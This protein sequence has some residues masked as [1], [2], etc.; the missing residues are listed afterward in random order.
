M[1]TRKILLFLLF[2][3][4]ISWISAG[5]VYLAGIPYGSTISLVVT[6]TFFMM[7]PAL[8][9]VIVQ[10][11][12]YKLP[13]KE[14]GLDFK[15]TKWRNMLWIALVQLLI[16]VFS[17]GFIILLGNALHIEA[18]G[19]YSFDPEMMNGRFRELSAAQGLAAVPNL[20]IPPVV[21][22]IIS[23]GS[24]IL[25]GGFIN[26]IFTFGEEL[27]WRGFLYNETRKLGFWKSNLLIGTIW[28]LWHAPL[29]LQGHNYPEHPV[30]GVFM[31]VPFCIS[32][33]FLMS[34]VRT[35][36]NSVLG[37]A[38]LHGMI[39]AGAGGVM[40]FAYGYNDLFGNIAG[41]AGILG[42]LL[43]L[44]VILIFDKKTISNMDLPEEE[45]LE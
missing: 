20:P 22:L 35:K 38:L 27:G 39:N 2:A 43:T 1:N 4:G 28:G 40:L 6:A 44:A 13:L 42:T 31:M 15:R 17:I 7:A 16:C 45:A 37:P 26:G 14:L 32:L 10:K 41:A 30:A 21:L 33:G 8:A 5:I 19:F 29:I 12:I 18:F 23:I 25:F 11:G 3:F 34:W 24:S 9:A 36:T